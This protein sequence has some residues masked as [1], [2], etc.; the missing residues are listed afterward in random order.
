MSQLVQEHF[1][2][3]WLARLLGDLTNQEISQFELKVD[4]KSGIALSKNPVCHDRSKHID[5]KYHYIQNCVEEGKIKINHV[6]TED[7]LADILTKSLGRI[8]FQEMRTRIG[9]Q[10][11]K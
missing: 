1:Q 5:I 2:G 3:V 8:K 9:V 10:S 11:V 7:Q 6:R 4:N